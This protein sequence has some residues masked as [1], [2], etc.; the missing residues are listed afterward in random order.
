LARTQ[1]R[2]RAKTDLLPETPADPLGI[3]PPAPV[4]ASPITT[5]PVSPFTTAPPPAAEVADSLAEEVRLLRDAR[6]ALDRGDPSRALV[7][8]DAHA[9]RFLHGTLY[10]ERLATRVLA[11]C[12]MG[13]IE[14]ARVAA[15]ELERAAPRSPHLGRVRASCIGATASP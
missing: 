7:S 13:R 9:S 10:E 4:A 8:L 6:A 1:R 11:L 15:E 12:A 5:P 14:A 2:P 3:T